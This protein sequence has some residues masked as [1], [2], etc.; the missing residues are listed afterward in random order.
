[1]ARHRV[2][3]F[4]LKFRYEEDELSPEAHDLVT[5][6]LIIDPKKR[7]G[8]NGAEEVKQHPFFKGINW[9]QLY[10]EEPP[11]TPDV[12]I[13]HVKATAKADPIID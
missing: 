10:N 12:D 5:K 13:N 1:M 2:I 8:Y 6:L 9:D 11:I 7:L 3:Y 4:L